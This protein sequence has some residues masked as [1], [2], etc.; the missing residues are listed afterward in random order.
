MTRRLLPAAVNWTLIVYAL[1]LCV[2]IWIYTL[3]RIQ[4]DYRATLEM[5]REHLRSVSGTFEAQ[6]EAML[7]DGVGAALAAANEYEDPGSCRCRR[8]ATGGHAHA[9]AHRRHLRSITFS[10]PA[11]GCA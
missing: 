10:E 1:V 4:S 3:E 8:C 5:E 6:V 11:T 7:G 9:H 2:G